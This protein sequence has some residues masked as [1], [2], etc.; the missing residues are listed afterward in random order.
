[1]KVETERRD[2]FY[3]SEVRSDLASAERAGSAGKHCSARARG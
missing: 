1:M 2:P 3:K